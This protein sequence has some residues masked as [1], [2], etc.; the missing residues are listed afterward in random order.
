MRFTGER[1]NHRTNNIFKYPGGEIPLVGSYS[2]IRERFEKKGFDPTAVEEILYSLWGGVA[3]EASIPLT[4]VA[5]SFFQFVSS[6]V[7]K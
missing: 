7:G 6:E 5:E 3:A 1:L 4:E 2:Q